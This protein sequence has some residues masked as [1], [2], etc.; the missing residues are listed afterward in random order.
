MLKILRS[1]MV[2]SRKVLMSPADIQTY[3]D[4]AKAVSQRSHAT[5]L[6]VGAIL[7]NSDR[8]MS[9]GYNGTPAGWENRCEDEHLNTLPEV[10]HAEMNCLFKFVQNGISTKDTT[11]FVTHSPCLEC[12]KP[13]YL[14]GISRVYYVDEYRS[15]SG[16]DFLRKANIEVVKL[17]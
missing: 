12:A 3:I 5:R 14:A 16:V 11:M 9:I 13:L 7:V 6:Q 4:M 8:I 17:R 10:I 1:P 15:T 2:T